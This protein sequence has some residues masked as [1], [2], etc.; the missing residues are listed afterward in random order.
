MQLRKAWASTA[1]TQMR[2]NHLW[3]A[4]IT[5]HGAHSVLVCESTSEKAFW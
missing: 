5:C 1:P 2:A 3:S 4:G